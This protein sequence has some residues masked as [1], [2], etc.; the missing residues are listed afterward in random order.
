M[1]LKSSSSFWNKNQGFRSVWYSVR[2][3][4]YLLC[5]IINSVMF[6]FQTWN[7]IVYIIIIISRF[8]YKCIIV[9]KYFHIQN[10]LKKVGQLT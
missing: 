4:Y 2:S 9:Y 3:V 1:A 6:P 5:V 10:K 8:N 7:C